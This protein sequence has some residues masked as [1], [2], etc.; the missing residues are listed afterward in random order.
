MVQTSLLLLPDIF[1]L[2][3]FWCLFPQTGEVGEQ[4]TACVPPDCRERAELLSSLDRNRA[5]FLYASQH[6]QAAGIALSFQG[7]P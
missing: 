2:S 7:I 1:S 5:L 4:C 6:W 3:V